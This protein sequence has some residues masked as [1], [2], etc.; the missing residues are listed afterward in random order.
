MERAPGAD[1][2]MF[3]SA[4]VAAH[5]FI[6]CASGKRAKPAY[7]DTATLDQPILNFGEET[8]HDGFNNG[9]RQF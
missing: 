1:L 7:L 4:G 3:A 9:G 8:G 5:A 6:A 2:Y